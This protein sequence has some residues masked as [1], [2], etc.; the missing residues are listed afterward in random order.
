MFYLIMVLLVTR[1]ALYW[2]ADTCT[3]QAI[4]L[5]FMKAISDVVSI[6]YVCERRNGGHDYYLSQQIE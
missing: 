3:I 2:L 5:Y 6:R 4:I 1:S